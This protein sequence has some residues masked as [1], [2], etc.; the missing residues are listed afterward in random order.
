MQLNWQVEWGLILGCK[1]GHGL[2]GFDSGLDTVPFNDPH[3]AL[4]L[5]GRARGRAG[6]PRVQGFVRVLPSSGAG[7]L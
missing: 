4:K 2:N 1:V 6:V 5:K 3:C 7:Y